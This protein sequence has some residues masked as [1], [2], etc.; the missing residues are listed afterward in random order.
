[1]SLRITSGLASAPL[2]L[3]RTIPP[4][5]TPCEQRGRGFPEED[6]SRHSSRKGPYMDS[7][8]LASARASASARKDPSVSQRASTKFPT[9]HSSSCADVQ[10]LERSRTARPGPG[11]DGAQSPVD[12]RSQANVTARGH[13][14]RGS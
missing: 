4:L 6:A 12:S 13:S 14:F 8:P 10:V 7:F 11:K 2:L 1:M 5:T 9:N 3:V